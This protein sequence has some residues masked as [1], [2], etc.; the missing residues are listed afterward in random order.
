MLA[1]EDEPGRCSTPCGHYAKLSSQSSLGAGVCV[2]ICVSVLPL[3]LLPAQDRRER[4]PLRVREWPH[5][6]ASQSRVFSDRHRAAKD[7]CFISCEQRTR[8]DKNFFLKNA[9]L[10]CADL[11]VEEFGDDRREGE[12]NKLNQR[13]CRELNRDLGI[14]SCYK[15]VC[16]ALQ[17]NLATHHELLLRFTSAGTSG[18]KSDVWSWT[19]RDGGLLLPAGGSG[20]G[21]EAAA[22]SIVKLVLLISTHLLCRMFFQSRCFQGV[23][24]LSLSFVGWIGLSQRCVSV[25]VCVCMCVFTCVPW[26]KNFELLLSDNSHWC[27]RSEATH[28]VCVISL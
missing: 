13:E 20:S 8:T 17:P 26:V 24:G 14:L 4:A 2:C 7:C 12:G 19:Q 27:C 23:F 18:G 9:Q 3:D 15:C 6:L 5:W 10:S 21:L 22:Q 11:N 16:A 25:C 1:S 28:S